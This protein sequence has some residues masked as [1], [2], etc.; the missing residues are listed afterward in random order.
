MIHM[1]YLETFKLLCNHLT[2]NFPFEMMLWSGL[3]FKVHREKSPGCCRYRRC[4]RIGECIICICFRMGS[5]T[6]MK[7]LRHHMEYIQ[8]WLRASCR[9]LRNGEDRL[10]ALYIY[11]KDRWNRIAMWLI[12]V[13]ECASIVTVSENLVLIEATATQK[14]CVEM[15]LK[16]VHYVVHRR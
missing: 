14:N 10:L 11:S 7:L 16:V 15:V 4:S 9:F 13:I 1:H 5:W 8:M 12:G 6:Y 3:D 2:Y